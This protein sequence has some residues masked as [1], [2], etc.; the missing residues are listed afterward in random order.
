VVYPAA[1]LINVAENS[2]AVIVEVNLEET[3]LSHLANYSYLGM[4]GEILPKIF[5][6]YMKAAS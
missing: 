2:G 4:A 3:P 6:E 5:N 1:G